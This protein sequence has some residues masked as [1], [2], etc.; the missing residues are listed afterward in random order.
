[1]KKSRK[2]LITWMLAAVMALTCGS[3]AAFADEV[4][5]EG[6]GAA[7]EAVNV[8]AEQPEVSPVD[9]NTDAGQEDENTDVSQEDEN[10][11]DGDYIMATL[12][13]D[14]STNREEGLLELHRKL[15]PGE[16]AS[17]EGAESL[18]N[19]MIFN[20][21]RYDLGNVGIFT[22]NRKFALA[23]RI[24]GHKAVDNIVSPE[25]EILAEKDQIITEEQAWNIQNSGIN[26]VDVIPMIKDG[27]TL[28]EADEK[29]RV[30]GNARVDAK[31]FLSNFFSEEIDK[32]I[33][34]EGTNI[35]SPCILYL[36]SL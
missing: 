17:T 14:N 30:I 36:P 12:A 10:F 6:E 34:F 19:N 26:E 25:G 5:T 35:G 28:T 16:P 1:M 7:G 11:G 18:L 13:K 20:P 8:E 9:E 29:F 15:R 23:S 21:Q 2:R 22:V 31:A 27:D 24:M 4:Q 33:D 3:G 32:D